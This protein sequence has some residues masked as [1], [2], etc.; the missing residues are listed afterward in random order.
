M[1]NGS[2][3]FE[4]NGFEIVADILPPEEWNVLANEL[5]ALH[6]QHKDA[7][8]NKLGG[9]RNLL[10]IQ[11]K[12]NELAN[13]AGF[14]SILQSRLNKPVFPVRALFF[15][16]TPDANWSVA[17]HQDVTIAVAE[18]IETPRFEA[19]SIKEDIIHV[20]P[21]REV[22]EGMATIRLHLDTCDAN[23][24][25]LKV[26]SGSHSGGKLDAVQIKERLSKDGDSICEVPKGGALLMR[27]LIIHSSSPSKSPSHR[28]V[29]H[30]EY[31]SDEL[32]NGLRWFERQ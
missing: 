30:I 5:S 3:Q 6:Q 9:L 4:K 26:I 27:P 32:P 18:R 20:Q 19:W 21:P 8:K 7:T 24:G 22:L 25:A 13:S 28:R 31:A 11:P 1:R 12:I 15:D 14:K 29:L 23:N 16:K 10:R 17:W 2:S